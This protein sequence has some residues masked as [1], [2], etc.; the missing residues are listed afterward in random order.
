[1]SSLV[2]RLAAVSAAVLLVVGCGTCPN[3]PFLAPSGGSPAAW[4]AIVATNAPMRVAVYAGRGAG[5]ESLFKLA[6]LAAMCPDF[7]TRTLDAEAI[8]RHALDDVDLLLM[9]GLDARELHAGLEDSGAA[10]IRGFVQRGGSLLA[11]SAAATYALADQ[12]LALA[13]YTNQPCRH[14]TAPPSINTY[15]NERANALAGFK[16]GTLMTRY[17]F[18]P[19]MLPASTEPSTIKTTAVFNGNVHTAGLDPAA[20]SMGKCA[21]AVAGPCGEGR[22]WLC[23]DHPEL[24]PSSTFAMRRILTYLA[25]GRV[26][27]LKHPQRTQGQLT[28][29]FLTLSTPTPDDVELALRLN[30]DRDFDLVPL[31]THT[32]LA[33]DL[34]HVDALV[35][36]RNAAAKLPDNR[37]L[38]ADLPQFIAHGGTVFKFT[39]DTDADEI[40]AKLRALKNAPAPQPRRLLRPTAA[41]MSPNPV[42]TLFYGADGAGGNGIF[43]VAR[44]FAASTNYV[45]RFVEGKDIRDGALKNA[46]L[47]IVP[48]GDSVSQSANLGPVGNTNLVN[49]IRNG[50]L[51][52]GTCAG[53]Y[54]VSQNR[55][56]AKRRSFLELTPFR[57]QRCPY[58]GGNSLVGIRYTPAGEKALGRR[59]REEMFYHGGPILLP[60]NP[61]ADSDYEV[62]ANFDSQN[63]YVYN[64]NTVPAMAEGAAIVAGRVGKGK[65][66]GM[67]PHPEADDGTE[68]IV[69]D[70]L[71]Y[72]T[73]RKVDG[74]RNWRT[75]GNLSVAFFCNRYYNDGGELALDLLDLPRFDVSAQGT[76]GVGCGCL[77]HLDLVV[78]PHPRAQ[79]MDLFKEFLARGGHV[80]VWYTNAKEK[81]YIPVD[82]KNVHVFPSAAACLEA[83]R[84]L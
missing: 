21:S 61:V 17:D 57:A 13:P 44:L 50:G 67:S 33:G 37:H 35:L 5:D 71:E 49:W 36:P 40:A 82:A 70:E 63:V 74:G 64:T 10:E 4:T 20:P 77:E 48:G 1:M 39:P 62:L 16:P 41:E 8:R 54:L 14:C 3:F 78:V 45:V 59:G 60:G 2:C 83:L 30:A 24:Y 81:S 73:G 29:G 79:T 23:A 38:A 75:R 80:Y 42:R 27:A 31:G 19:V 28:V 69:R 46:D 72:L 66:L 22:I 18:G 65:V 56:Q 47:Y 58:R 43:R 15:Y 34:S 84:K 7:Q 25:H 53:A 76:R 12:P 11:L 55:P 68:D 51:Y 52:H 32:L 9:T 6:R 26:P